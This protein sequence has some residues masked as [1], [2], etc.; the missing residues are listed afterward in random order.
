MKGKL[1][2]QIF[3]LNL[4]ERIVQ[5]TGEREELFF[6]LEGRKNDDRDGGRFS[7]RTKQKTKEERNRGRRLW[8]SLPMRGI[9]GTKEMAQT[10]HLA[11]TEQGD[12]KKDEDHGSNLVTH[13]K[14]NR[15]V[16][17]APR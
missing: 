3:G 4:N 2:W 12:R 14:E 17:H 1:I 15:A 11:K 7:N 16:I 9:C 5:L 6:I 8:K 13:D 10:L